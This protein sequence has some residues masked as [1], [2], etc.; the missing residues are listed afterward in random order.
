MLFGLL[1]LCYANAFESLTTVESIGKGFAITASHEGIESLTKNPAGTLTSESHR[2]YSSYASYFGLYQ[3]ASF[4]Y[5][6]A[7]DSTR[8]LTI[9]VPMTY[10]TDI[11][12]T[13][14]SGGEALQVGTFSD[15]QIG[16]SVGVASKIN[17]SLSMG[18]SLH[19]MMHLIDEDRS[20]MFSADFGLIYDLPYIQLG[21]S[22]TN[23]TLK[24]HQWDTETT[25][26]LPLTI[27]TGFVAD[28]VKGS[29]YG[30]IS[31]FDESTQVNGG[32]EWHVSSRLDIYAGLFDAF[33]TSQLTGGVT[34]D[35]DR[36][37]IMYAT[38]PHE[39]LG[40]IQKMGLSI[41]L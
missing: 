6:T 34:L 15:Q 37:E 41:L 7:I 38:L 23:I 5:S 14:D 1:P 29:M 39:T 27:N 9:N 36:L 8:S 22:V 40:V 35:L 21:A 32:L 17:Q 18:T 25:E 16:F 20:Q 19:M 28:L 26:G 2:I 10:I 12:K 4:G 24:E 13:I 31:F 33:Q 11:P 30:D 3:T